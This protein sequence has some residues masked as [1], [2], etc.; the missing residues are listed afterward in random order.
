MLRKV[1]WIIFGALSAIALVFKAI[2]GIL[3]FILCFA[4]WII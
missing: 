3:G 1:L 4:A 2:L